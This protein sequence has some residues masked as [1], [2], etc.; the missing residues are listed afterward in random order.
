MTM[1]QAASRIIA[2]SWSAFALPGTPNDPV[3]PTSLPSRIVGALKR[4][5]GTPQLLAARRRLVDGWLLYE[6]SIRHCGE[7]RNVLV[8]IGGRIVRLTSAGIGSAVPG[9]A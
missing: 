7:I 1:Q 5:F 8:T 4:Q 6:L 9:A 3:P 2:T